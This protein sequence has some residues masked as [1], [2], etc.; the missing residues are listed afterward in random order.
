MNRTGRLFVVGL[1]PGDRAT[2][3]A[4]ALAALQQ[5]EVTPEHV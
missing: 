3:T 1:G 5:A 2:M 4:Q